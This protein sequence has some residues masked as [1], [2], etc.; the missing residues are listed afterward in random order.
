MIIQV[1]IY[2]SLSHSVSVPDS[3]REGDKC[4]IPEG[5][6]V[7]QFF[8]MLNVPRQLSLIILVNGKHA[9]RENVL[10]DG[11]SLHMLLPMTGG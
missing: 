9:S 7:G 8:E 6:T 11:D 3:L 2:G 10:K 5:A 4:H 1:K